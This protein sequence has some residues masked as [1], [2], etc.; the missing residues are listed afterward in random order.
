MASAGRA[1]S[2]AVPAQAAPIPSPAPLPLRA[3]R[4]LSRQ[5]EEGDRSTNPS[6]PP[7]PARLPPYLFPSRRP[8]P[9]P[10]DLPPLRPPPSALR[11]PGGPCSELCRLRFS[12]GREVRGLTDSCCHHGAVR[13]ERCFVALGRSG[14]A[15]QGSREAVQLQPSAQGVLA[16]ASESS[17]SSLGVAGLRRLQ[18]Q[19]E[20]SVV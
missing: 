17:S 14:E 1:Q 4:A 15:E 5:Q 12:C 13:G 6:L 3:G 11:P 18:G 16:A 2:P 8:A 19:R 10:S 20:R 9:P 7:E